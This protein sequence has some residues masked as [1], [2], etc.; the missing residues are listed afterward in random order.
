MRKKK[1]K[2]RYNM[3]QNSGFM[4]RMAW[5]YEKQTLS[6]A[7]LEVIAVVG[8][9]LVNL[10]VAPTILNAVQ[11]RVSIGE[12]LF[13]IITF[14]LLLILFNSLKA[15][16]DQNVVY[17]RI[18]VRSALSGLLHDKICTTSYVNMED[19]KFQLLSDKATDVVC[20]NYTASEQIWITLVELSQSVLGFLL[21]LLM[22]TRFE[23][24]IMILI[25][26]TAMI[27]YVVNNKLSNYEY[28]HREEV[29]KQ[30][31]RIWGY[32][33]AACDVRIAKDIR[34]F[35]LKPWLTEVMDKAV[36]AFNAFYIKAAKL[37]IVGNIVDLLLALLR[38]GVAYAYLIGMVLD[39]Q[40][41][42]AEFLLYFT[43]VDG[44]SNWVTGILN[45]MT[46]LKRQSID[47]CTVRECLEWPEPFQ[48][49]EGNPLVPLAQKTYAISL[50]DVSFRYPG[51]EEDTISHLNLTLHA[52]EKLAVVG[53]NGAG[54]TTLIKLMCGFLDPTA[55]RVLLDGVDVRNYN[56]RDYYKMFCA[57]FQENALLAGSVAMN[58]A[59]EN[60]N[61]DMEKVKRCIEQAGL[62]EKIESLPDQYESLMER[63]VYED[64]ITL[65]GGETQRLM[66]AR[67]L[68][69]NAPI[70]MLDEPTAALDPLAEEDIYMKYNQ[71]TSGR[72]SVYIS[73]RLASTRFCDRIVLLQDG[74]ILEEGTHA[75]LMTLGGQ[76]AQLFEVQS[77]YYRE[78]AM[79]DE[80]IG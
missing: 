25:I 6:F 33:S 50:E 55:G 71:M 52:G 68:Y 22:L 51:A 19:K 28:E 35:G 56:R 73:H 17:G 75:Q 74:K 39:H 48:F 70:I 2:P 59:Q 30:S 69:K 8:I 58:V 26:V 47:I 61:I 54:K 12:V 16:V 44:F 7:L 37:Y 41:S 15:Y 62:T 46:K 18:G 64:A 13:T 72:S 21:F 3:W 78:G 5:K 31:N 65:S 76:Y 32:Q 80:E 23:I 79:E 63:K 66:L 10:Y 43:A 36:K 34:I 14:T 24:S 49:E 11:N 77:R 53:L 38:N 60:K 9:S 20:S 1:D 40:L 67:A 57:V 29:S 42:A 45:N 4:I 27:G